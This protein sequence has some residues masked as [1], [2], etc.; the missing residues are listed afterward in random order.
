MFLNLTTDPCSVMT[1]KYIYLLICF[2][3]ASRLLIMLLDS[4]S[5]LVLQSSV[6]KGGGGLGVTH[7]L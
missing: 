1:E 3:R 7:E 6:K 5:V 4:V 2:M